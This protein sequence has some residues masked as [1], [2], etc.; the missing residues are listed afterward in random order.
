MGGSLSHL[1]SRPL[2]LPYPPL[3]PL[4]MW[5]A[6]VPDVAFKEEEGERDHLY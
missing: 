2:T 6:R 4:C 1:Q 3:A 5:H